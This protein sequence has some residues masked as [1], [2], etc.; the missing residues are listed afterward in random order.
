M[1]VGWFIDTHV[2]TFP[3]LTL[4]GL[5]IGI[6]AASYYLFSLFQQ[7]RRDERSR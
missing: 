1:A 2:H 6:F 7:S 4:V 5:A 3:G